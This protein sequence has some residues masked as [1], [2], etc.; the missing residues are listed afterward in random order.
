MRLIRSAALG[1]A[2]LLASSSPVPVLAEPA[3]VVMFATFPGLETDALPDFVARARQVLLR[4][5]VKRGLFR[6]RYDHSYVIA[7]DP[8]QQAGFQAAGFA[9]PHR[10]WMDL[11][12]RR[13]SDINGWGA[14]ANGE[15]TREMRAQVGGDA[16]TGSGEVFRALDGIDTDI[17]AFTREAYPEVYRRVLD[18]RAVAMGER[19][20]AFVLTYGIYATQVRGDSPVWMLGGTKREGV[21]RVR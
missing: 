10:L 5:V 6:K 3:S 14:G 19:G 21:F 2:A 1:L 15:V 12:F 13:I 9:V 20:Y 4:K 11:T 17:L 16:A 8:T 18:P 7:V